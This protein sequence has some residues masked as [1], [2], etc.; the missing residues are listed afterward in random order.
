MA[1]RYLKESPK[2]KS[3]KLW[4][5]LIPVLV[6]LVGLGIAGWNLL[7]SFTFVEPVPDVLPE[8]TGMQ[9]EEV[10]DPTMASGV[11]DTTG[12]EG[13]GEGA[14]T[15]PTEGNND[16]FVPTDVVFP[17]A[18]VSTIM[19]VGQNARED[20]NH[21]LSDTMIMCTIN[22]DTKTL[23]M[24]SFLRDLYVPIPAYAGHTA[25]RNRMNVC[26][27]LGTQWTGTEAGGMEM[28]ALCV[29]QN[30]GIQIDNTVEVGLENFTYII[31]NLGGVDIE[32]TEAE[33][34]YM[35]EEVGYVGD[36]EPGMQT[37]N[38]KEALAYCRIRAIDS[39][40]NRTDRQRTLIT[41]MLKKLSKMN[42]VELYKLA[43]RMLVL[44]KTDM[45]KGEILGYIWNF[46]KILPELEIV[47][48]R[49][50]LEKSELGAWSYSGHP[51]D[52]IGNVLEPNLW[53]HKQYLQNQLGYTDGE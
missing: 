45:T 36:M 4:F 20:E 49:V 46:L 53:A 27:H 40:F 12:E 31:D 38:G 39:D 18:D 1:G 8:N 7:G 26:Y 47:S 35:T 14:D 29:K 2:K 16:D 52:G 9:M 44:I 51:V 37:L 15:E 48:Q 19:L 43:E 30:F 33:A 32:L 41:S 10:T 23:Y 11:E 50:P 28:L 42:V 6:L 21:R 34:R 24:T 25:G 5:I 3:K 13:S 22:W 17:T